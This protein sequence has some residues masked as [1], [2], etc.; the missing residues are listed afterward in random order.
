M[1]Y[2]ENKLIDYLF[3]P[4]RT[5]LNLADYFDSYTRTE[6]INYLARTLK[7]RRPGE[8][9]HYLEIGVRN[10]T[11]NFN[12]I[13]ADVKYSVDPGLE[14]LENP[15][16]FKMTSDEFF[17]SLRGGQILEKGILF[18]LIFIDGL[19]LADQVK[20][21]IENASEFL[22]EGGFIVM[23][24]CNPPESS[25]ARE[26]YGDVKNTAGGSWNGTTW[27]AFVD[28][29]TNGPFSSCCIN[30]DFGVGIISSTDYLG[31]NNVIPNPFFEYNL[32]SEYRGEMLN[33]M[34][35]DRLKELV[36]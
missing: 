23:H 11:D 29:R 31:P 12:H 8:A 28:Y 33:L 6:I 24:D 21:D 2:I 18:D 19:H 1:K 30:S 10:P 26:K 20:K 4:E 17:D 16:D 22:R 15:V 35:F 36:K 9:L 5:A 7:G 25:F 13:E 34:T 27:K 3:K 32:L 14:N